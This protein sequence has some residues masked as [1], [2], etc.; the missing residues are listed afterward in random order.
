[1]K[2]IVFI[3][4]SLGQGGAQKVMCSI[5]NF[6]VEQNFQVSII[7]IKNDDILV[8]CSQKIKLYNLG[9]KKV[10]GIKNLAILMKNL[11]LYKFLK[12]I[13][14]D[15]VVMFTALT[16]LY[17]FGAV[18]KINKEIICAE[19]DNPKAMGKITFNLLQFVYKHANKVIFQMDGAR[20]CF[21]DEVIRKSYIIPNACNLKDS[22]LKYDYKKCNNTIVAAGRLEQVKRFDVLLKAFAKLCETVSDYELVIFG[23]GQ[24]KKS[25]ENL[26]E[27]LNIKNRVLFK[28]NVKHFWHSIELPR[29][30]VLSSDSEGIPNVIIEALHYGIPCISTDCEPGGSRMLLEN[31]KIG[32]L[33]ER[34]NVFELSYAMNELINNGNKCNELSQRGL[35]AIKKYNSKDILYEWL[36]I[37][38]GNK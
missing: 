31:G 8:N 23:E 27:E 22:D 30:F 7:S 37:I 32:I 24:L 21:C 9:I 13:D 36:K 1:M 28:G 5:A 15:I 4:T 16:S 20:D 35:Q 11:K 17:C 33:V 38:E 19:R 14:P 34:D 26:C 25:L 10:G 12:E 29:M 18:K 3:T 2:K 6:Y